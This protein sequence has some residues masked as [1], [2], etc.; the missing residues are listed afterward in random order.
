MNE[1]KLVPRAKK[2]LFMGYLD[3]VKGYRIWCPE[4]RKCII[5][6]DVTFNE[7]S[8]QNKGDQAQAQGG[9][10]NRLE[11]EV[12]SSKRNHTNGRND[13][14]NPERSGGTEPATCEQESGS[15]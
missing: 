9:D 1:G 5:S 15:D 4:S 3:G 10:S 11:L 2:G 6:R 8:L 14:P 12:E 13:D 7:Q